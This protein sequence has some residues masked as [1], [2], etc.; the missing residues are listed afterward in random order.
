MHFSSFV[1]LF[2]QPF[3]F[4]HKVICKDP[5]ADTLKTVQQRN[6]CLSLSCVGEHAFEKKPINLNS[7]LTNLTLRLQIS[8]F[9]DT[10][11]FFF[12][13]FFCMFV[14]C[15]TKCTVILMLNII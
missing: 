13:P 6:K 3:C 10:F 1:V 7:Y 14:F 11:F 9:S 15:A 8:S 12:S 5:I 2:T 4:L